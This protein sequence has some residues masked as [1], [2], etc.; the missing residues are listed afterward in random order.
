M[1]KGFGGG[2]DGEGVNVRWRVA[3][4]IQASKIKTD[5]WPYEADLVI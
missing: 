1:G 2:W 3:R 5:P 4:Q